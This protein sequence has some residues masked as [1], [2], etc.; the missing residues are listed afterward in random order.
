MSFHSADERRRLSP[1]PL[2]V[3]CA[4]DAPVRARVLS[5]L[6]ANERTRAISDGVLSKSRRPRSN[7]YFV[8]AIK[9]G[10]LNG[11]WQKKFRDGSGNAAA[12][13]EKG[14]LEISGAND[15][16]CP[17]QQETGSRGRWPGILYLHSALL[18]SYELGRDKGATCKL[19]RKWTDERVD[20]Q[21]ARLLPS[22]FHGHYLLRR[23]GE[24]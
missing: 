2:R 20:G 1:V 19:K 6:A 23:C 4:S 3:R 13:S 5:V 22:R 9:K 11:Y 21:G 24:G 7:E 8:K 16:D 14:R 17:N 15:G 12:D 10:A 18:P